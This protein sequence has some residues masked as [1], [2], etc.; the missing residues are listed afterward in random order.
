MSKQTLFQY[1]V[2]WHPTDK[3]AKDGE[4]SKLIIPPTNVLGKNEKATVMKITMDIPKE[5]EDQLDQ[6]DILIRPF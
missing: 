4:K 6:I 5:Y 3:Q 2:I 1:A